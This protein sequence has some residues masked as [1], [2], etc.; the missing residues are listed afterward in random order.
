MREGRRAH[1]TVVA[2]TQVDKPL[3][4][5]DQEFGGDRHILVPAFL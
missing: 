3:L 4:P 2:V 5:C 1:P